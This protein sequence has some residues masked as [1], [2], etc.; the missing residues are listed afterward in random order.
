MKDWDLYWFPDYRC[1]WL[2][3]CPFM[4]EGRPEVKKLDGV[5]PVDNRPS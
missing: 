5:G 1:R 3:N 4:G 2:G